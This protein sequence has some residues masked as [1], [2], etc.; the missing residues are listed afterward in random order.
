VVLDANTRVRNKLESNQSQFLDF[1]QSISK[2]NLIVVTFVLS[3]PC[4]V[5]YRG[6]L[7]DEGKFSLDVLSFCGSNLAQYSLNLLY[8]CV[9][10][11]LLIYVTFG[12]ALFLFCFL[13]FFLTYRI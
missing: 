5:I 6:S 12:Y 4:G 8:T 2:R 1:T 13:F 11:L 9:Y 7:F 3:N 10:L